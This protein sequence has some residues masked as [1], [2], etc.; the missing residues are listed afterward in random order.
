MGVV[1]VDEAA[2]RER[3][4]FVQLVFGPDARG[5]I[6]QALVAVEVGLIET[7]IEPESGRVQF[8]ARQTGPQQQGQGQQ[9]GHHRVAKTSLAACTV[10]AMSAS[11][12]A[13]LTKP[14]SYSAGAM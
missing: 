11:V 10:A 13:A 4:G 9:A 6:A 2:G 1:A 8:R 12:W 14:A 3:P 5:G 7:G